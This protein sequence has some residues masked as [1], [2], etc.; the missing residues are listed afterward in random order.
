MLS[1][2]AIGL[3]WYHLPRPWK[4]LV[5]GKIFWSSYVNHKF[6][7][8][9]KLP[10]SSCAMLMYSVIRTINL[11]TVTGH[12]P[13][14]RF[15]SDNRLFRFRNCLC[16]PRQARR[17]FR[18]APKWS[19]IHYSQRVIITFLESYSALVTGQASIGCW[20][21][22]SLSFVWFQVLLCFGVTR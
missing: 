5:S 12:W 18:D 6:H 2:S 22:H 4:F 14:P 21:Q 11:N 16:F 3:G 1:D 7:N 9:P 19:E 17:E 8:R 20:L 10:S 15:I 13:N